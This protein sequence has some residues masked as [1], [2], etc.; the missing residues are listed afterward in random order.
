MLAV[1]QFQ[2]LYNPCYHFILVCLPLDSVAELT[3]LL[4]WCALKE[5]LK[6]WVGIFTVIAVIRG[7]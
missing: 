5:S 7:A 2:E 6:K 1:W 4:W 3:C